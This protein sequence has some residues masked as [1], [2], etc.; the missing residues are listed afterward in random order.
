MASD[1]SDRTSG[2]WRPGTPERNDSGEETTSDGDGLLFELL[3]EQTAVLRQLLEENYGEL[4]NDTAPTEI[5]TGALGA[6]LFALRDRP[7]EGEAQRGAGN[8]RTGGVER[9]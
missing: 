8:G 4:F 5:Y 1:R 2:C 6:A 3:T 7:A 9:I